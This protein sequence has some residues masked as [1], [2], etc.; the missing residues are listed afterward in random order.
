[1]QSLVDSSRFRMKIIPEV[2][3]MSDYFI[4]VPM[5]HFLIGLRFP[6]DPAFA[7]FLNFVQAQPAHIHLNAV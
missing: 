2:L 6:I 1:M 4:P 7:F 3:S 5:V